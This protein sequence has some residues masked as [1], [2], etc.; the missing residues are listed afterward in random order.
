MNL[1]SFCFVMTVADEPFE[2]VADCLE[3]LLHV[4]PTSPVVVISDGP[5]AYDEDKLR[6]GGMVQ[7]A[8]GARLK[9]G[10]QNGALWWHRVFTH[11][12]A[13]DCS[14]IIKLDAD[15]RIHRPIRVIPIGRNGHNL[16]VAGSLQSPGD[17][18]E[19]VQGG[20]QIFTR[21]FARLA[22]YEAQ[23]ARYCNPA[24]WNLGEA[25]LFWEKGEVSTDY[26]LAVIC[27]RIGGEMIEHP[28]IDCRAIV[29]PK[30]FQPHAAATHPH[31][32]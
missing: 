17:K 24:N 13:Q 15:T 26:M 16:L 11:G 20:F 28:E 32:T 1:F 4:Y 22:M 9:I 18:D 3:R 23:D 5:L 12:L 8:P 10:L 29:L 31:K 14:Y 21:A 30:P 6:L 27:Q 7:Y 25:K 19:H 2:K